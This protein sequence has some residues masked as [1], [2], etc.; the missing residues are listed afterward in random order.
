MKTHR[1][2]TNWL[3]DLAL[4]V[5]FLVAFVL[6]LTG[7]P[8]HQLLGVL[9]GAVAAGTICWRIGLGSSRSL[10]GCA[11]ARPTSNAGPITPW[12]R[13]SCLAYS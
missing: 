4:F 2:K 3:I 12:M 7:L 11:R 9:V 6:D 8:L 5:G 1:P 10:P 13:V